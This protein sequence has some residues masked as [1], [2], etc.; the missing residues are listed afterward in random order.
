MEIAGIQI[1]MLVKQG[2]KVA[3]LLADAIEVGV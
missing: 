3:G 1:D 2:G